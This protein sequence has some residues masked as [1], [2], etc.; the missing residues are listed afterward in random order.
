M[1]SFNGCPDSEPR[2]YEL[3]D[4]IETIATADDLVLEKLLGLAQ[5]Q[6]SVAGA[7]MSLVGRRQTLIASVGAVQ[8]APE[9][10]CILNVQVVQN[11]ET[12]L[13]VEDMA[14]DPRSRGDV[15][16][17]EEKGR[18]YAGAPV[19]VNG[20][21]VGVLWVVDGRPRTLDAHLSSLLQDFADLIGE[22]LA[23][24]QRN[25]AVERAL[26]ASADAVIVVDD[27]Q[28][29]VFWSP[30]AERLFGFSAQEALGQT[31]RL[32]G[33]SCDDIYALAWAQGP[34][35][36]G[37]RPHGG[38]VETTA[39]CKD[40][41]S[42]DIEASLAVWHDNGLKRTS[43]AL[44]DISQRKRDTAALLQAKID[45]GAANVAKSAF[46]ANMSHE[47]RTPLNGVIGVADLL[48]RTVLDERQRELVSIIQT[49]SA[50]LK[51]LIG[52][53]LD[54]ARIET[55]ELALKT[56]PFD[57]RDEIER[58]FGLCAVRASQKGLAFNLE[59]DVSG[60]VIG[61]AV[62]LKQVL[63]N[64]L[65]NAIKFTEAGSVALKVSR[66][67]M[68]R[69]RF[70]I[71]DTG[72][73]FGPDE[74][75]ALF[76][77]FHQAD[78]AI[79]RRFGGVGL[80]LTICKELV[81][82]MGGAIDASGVPGQG[83]VFWFE[84]PLRPAAHPDA[85]A[86]DDREVEATER[87]AHILI[88]DDNETNRRVV[89][90]ILTSLGMA[91][92]SVEDGLEALEAFSA[93][94]FDVILMDMMMPRMDGLAATRAIREIEA[95]ASAGRTPIIMLTANTLPDHVA[96]AFQ[97]GA[98]L[99]LAKPVTTQSLADA[100]SCMFCAEPE[101]PDSIRWGEHRS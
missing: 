22:R 23:G 57:L 69:F 76:G 45:A 70:E 86:V 24:R 93:Q 34:P 16:R 100:L 63:V 4:S 33:L 6:L 41:S 92:V 78:G 96:A 65:N 35:E 55:G 61:D 89:E 81:E 18:F 68:D 30:G 28:R 15:G 53:I 8:H 47:L 43:V 60:W 50:Q 21:T 32:I 48:G 17:A 94:A 79:T 67:A 11:P 59:T 71:H 62:R 51:S 73:G 5:R 84:L 72:I 77:R 12:V 49:S 36:N 98:D 38:R 74:Q 56:E 39:V 90:L 83:A 26:E 31:G 27:A 91:T 66:C 99:H 46:L 3:V 10:H 19:R 75:A 13:W 58:G 88:V 52:E 97:A 2:R 40:G 25:F 1:M 9:R 44:R 85:S 80:G 87:T 82:A 37:V 20:E 95:R 54:L 101:Q 14:T 64:L 42:I 29:Y 7:L